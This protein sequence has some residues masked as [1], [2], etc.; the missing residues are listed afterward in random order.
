M[1]KI[2]LLT[3]GLMS[4]AA[5]AQLTDNFDDYA[6]G[7]VS[8][9]APHIIVWPAA[10][11]TD[12][13]VS[14]TFA[15]SAPNSMWLRNN[16]TDDVIVQLGDKTSGTWTVSFEVYVTSGATGFWNIQNF[17][18]ADPAQWNGQFFI[19]ATGSGGLPGMVITDLDGGANAVSYTENTWFNITHVINL[20]AQT[21]VVTVGGQELYN[22]DYIEG[23]T[24]NLSTQ[25]GGVNFYSIDTNNNYY[26]DDFSF[27]DGTASTEDFAFAQFSVY[28]NPVV[29]I[30]NIKSNEV[31]E[32][33]SI[34]NVLGQKVNQV[35]PNVASPSVDMSAL[36]SGVYFVEVII[37]GHSQT[38]KVVK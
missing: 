21:H 16:N 20:D 15:K 9:Q 24:G 5:T 38:V 29:D 1:K 17:E 8:P 37:A 27:I 23:T 28:P 34:Y 18:T 25:L 26:I 4:I 6:P 35:A 11:V 31:V 10:G 22:G 3:I 33:V 7:D 19:G 2:Y 13:Q 14:S 30:L 32:G 12:A 36:K